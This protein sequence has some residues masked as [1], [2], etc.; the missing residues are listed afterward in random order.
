MEKLF[1]NRWAQALAVFL[2]FTGIISPYWYFILIVGYFLV[3][4]WYFVIREEKPVKE[5]V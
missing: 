3:G 1:K 5:D 2:P 4:G